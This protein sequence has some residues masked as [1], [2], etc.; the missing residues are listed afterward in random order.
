MR[1]LLLRFLVFLAALWGLGQIR[2][3]EV[4]VGVLMI[5]VL[6]AMLHIWATPNGEGA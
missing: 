5:L 6:M 1:K 3:P 2:L 4:M